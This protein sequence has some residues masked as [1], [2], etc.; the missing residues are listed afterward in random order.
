MGNNSIASN[1]NVGTGQPV[2]TVTV[3][4]VSVEVTAAN[5]KRAFILLAN[6]STNDCWIGIDV[7]PAADKG[8]LLGKNGGTLF[9][10]ALAL[11]L[12]A[13]NGICKSGQ[14][15]TIVYQEFEK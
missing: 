6:T 5:T 12:G 13:I 11:S 8:I 14:T 15:A 1:V 10:D 2:A 7:T 9:L 3:T 4:D